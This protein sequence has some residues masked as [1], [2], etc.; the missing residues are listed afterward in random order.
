MYREKVGKARLSK[1]IMFDNYVFNVNLLVLYE[2]HLNS[3]YSNKEWGKYPPKVHR[4]NYDYKHSKHK[5][6]KEQKSQ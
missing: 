2:S 1:A 5:N 3:V 6:T 4:H